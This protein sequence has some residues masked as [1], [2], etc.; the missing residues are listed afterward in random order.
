M[1]MDDAG[2]VS[3][4][5]LVVVALSLAM[6]AVVTLLSFSLFGVKDSIRDSITLYAK[7]ALQL[8]G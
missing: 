5:H 2:Q 1:G 8:G 4:E 6:A 7:R 3:I